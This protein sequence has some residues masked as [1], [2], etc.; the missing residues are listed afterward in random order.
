MKKFY[1]KLIQTRH[2]LHRHQ[3]CV[4][5][6]GIKQRVRILD[7]NLK[8]GIIALKSAPEPIIALS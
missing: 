6:G 5:S 2:Y 4:W 1:D 8:N 3:N 7:S